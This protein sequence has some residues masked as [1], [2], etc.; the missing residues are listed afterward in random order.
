MRKLSFSADD[1]GG[2]IVHADGEK[3]GEI[4]LLRARAE[5]DPNVVRVGR[6]LRAEFRAMRCVQRLRLD[7]A[8]A[9]AAVSPRLAQLLSTRSERQPSREA[10]TNGMSDIMEHLGPRVAPMEETRDLVRALSAR[11][12]YALSREAYGKINRR[13]LFRKLKEP[14][15]V[16]AKVIEEA[17]LN[18]NTVPQSKHTH[19]HL[20]T[21][22]HSR[23]ARVLQ[24]SPRP[25]PLRTRYDQRL[26][27]DQ[28]PLRSG[29]LG[30]Y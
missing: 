4:R 19:D 14:V 1:D 15:K 24:Q 8:R 20:Q 5:L 6:V 17:F 13:A 9:V 3:A 26:L 2:R 29:A 30:L 27:H 23:S 7:A 11:D 10:M 25:R 22:P 21:R 12:Y 16:P 18:E 28:R